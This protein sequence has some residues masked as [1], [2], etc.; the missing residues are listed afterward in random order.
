MELIASLR[1]PVGFYDPKNPAMKAAADPDDKDEVKSIE[2]ASRNTRSPMLS[3]SNTDMAFKDNV[4]VAGVIMDLI[5]M[6]L[7]MMAF[8]L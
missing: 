8:L 6:I 2:E 3:F 4:L 1:K 7:V 5:F